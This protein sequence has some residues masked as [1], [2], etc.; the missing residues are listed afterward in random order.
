LKR[1]EEK[2]ENNQKE[3]SKNK[4]KKEKL[5]KK[6][7]RIVAHVNNFDPKTTARRIREVAIGAGGRGTHIS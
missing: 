2:E 5:K 7:G 3:R 4:G 1:R 6:L